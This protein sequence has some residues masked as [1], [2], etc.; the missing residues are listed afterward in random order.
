MTNKM[1]ARWINAAIEYSMESHCTVY[2]MS[3]GEDMIY[4]RETEIREGYKSHGYWVAMIFEN[5]YRVE[6]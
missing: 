2:L 4:T 5:G 1:I 3:N 6:A